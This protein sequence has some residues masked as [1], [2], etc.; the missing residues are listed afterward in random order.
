MSAKRGRPEVEIDL[1][2]LKLLSQL[3][4][5]NFEIAASLG[6]S[7]RTINTRRRNEE[8]REV[9]D[10][11]EAIGNVSLRR[12]QMTMAL[13]GD[14]TMLI[15]LGKQR[16]QQKDKIETSSKDPIK[17]PKIHVEFVTPG[18][19]KKEDKEE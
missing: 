2:K 17:P 3:G 10:R 19:S 8:F 7:E 12:K 9:M 16:L 6:V 4:C 13:G 1:Q 14:R 18:A 5:T 11:A 15:W